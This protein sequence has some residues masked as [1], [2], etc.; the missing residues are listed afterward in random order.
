MTRIGL[1]AGVIIILIASVFFG[2]RKAMRA[3]N[4]EAAPPRASE[5]PASMS[6]PASSAQPKKNPLE[7]PRPLRRIDPESRKLL[8]EELARA[9]AKRAPVPAVGGGA[10]AEQQLSPDYILQQT[11]AIVPLLR[12]C[13]T[14]AQEDDPTLAG[15][16]ALEIEIGGEPDVG[17]LVES[18]EILETS[19]IKHAG[20]AECVRETMYGLELVAPAEGGRYKVRTT[21]AFSPEPSGSS[22]R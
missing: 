6:A 2:F 14:R 18:S 9:R 3:A 5:R 17:G 19:T 10:P 7:E 11:Q 12:E 4:Q 16:L 13:Y 21:V 20:M 22:S 1:V 8:V 15:Q